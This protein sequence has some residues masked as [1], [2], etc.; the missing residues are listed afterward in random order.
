MGPGFTLIELLVVIAIIGIL[1]AMLLPSLSQAKQRA[2]TVKCLSNLRQ[3]GVALEAYVSDNRQTF[4]AADSFQSDPTVT[5]SVTY[6]EFLGGIDSAEPYAGIPEAKARPLAR[7]E[8][9]GE[10]FRCPSDGGFGPVPPP[11]PRYSS[12]GCS[13]RLNGPLPRGYTGPAEDPRYNLA[14]KKSSWPPDPSRF[15]A[16]HE[17][18]AYAYWDMAM[19]DAAVNGWHENPRPGEYFPFDQLTFSPRQFV[20]TALFVDGHS[21]KCDFTQAIRNN[22][23]LA[24]E[25]TRN[26]VWYKPRQ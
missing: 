21:Q 18:A 1:A 11:F 13:Y 17:K 3:I 24:L 26:W 6:S 22:P 2:L 19:G 20:G 4:P 16:V 23:K 7:Y 9:A 14:G 12:L 10:V 5:P 8:P 25:P 15:I